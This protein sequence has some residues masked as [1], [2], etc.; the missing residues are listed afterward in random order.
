MPIAQKID[1]L[2]KKFD[3]THGWE[4]RYKLIIEMGKELN[5]YPEKLR[6]ETH[7]VKG[8]Q[9]Q[10]WL[11]AELSASGELILHGDS[12]A[13]IVKGLVALLLAVYNGSTPEEVLATPPEFIKKL[14]LEEH[15]SPSRSN[16]F[17][18]M[19]KQVF[20]YAQVFKMTKS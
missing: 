17:F 16:G 20:L 6:D 2:L 19:L 13:L 1:L 15:L 18:A 12:D 5:E 4:N 10:V 8:C 3:S 11:S 7:K 14:G 9:S